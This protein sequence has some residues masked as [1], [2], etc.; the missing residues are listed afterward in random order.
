[1]QKLDSGK[2]A[3]SVFFSVIVFTFLLNSFLFTYIEIYIKRNVVSKETCLDFERLQGGMAF[4]KA[5]FPLGFTFIEI[6]VVLIL[7][8][9]ISVLL[10]VKTLYYSKRNLLILVA[11]TFLSVFCF[12]GA[13]SSIDT[14][15]H[16]CV[17]IL[18]WQ[19]GK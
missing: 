11:I 8:I 6:S 14:R 10:R 19:T 15:Y 18:Y 17:E 4:C 12:V 3:K 2:L 9:L 5:L 7:V 1:M 16:C 13:Q